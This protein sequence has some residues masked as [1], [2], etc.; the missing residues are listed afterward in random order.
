MQCGRLV[1]GNVD[2]RSPAQNSWHPDLLLRKAGAEAFRRAASEIAEAVCAARDGDRRGA[3]RPATRDAGCL[4]PGT[5]LR[6]GQYNRS[7]PRDHRGSSEEASTI[8]YWLREDT[9]HA[10]PHT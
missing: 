1:G 5:R 3:T 9:R 10:S 8:D 2:D 6:Q 7:G 4:R